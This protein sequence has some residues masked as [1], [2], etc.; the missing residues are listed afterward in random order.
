M[1][2]HTPEFFNFL[3]RKDFDW[4]SIAEEMSDRLM[5]DEF[6][7]DIAEHALDIAFKL[8]PDGSDSDSELMDIRHEFVSEFMEHCRCEYV[9]QCAGNLGMFTREEAKNNADI[10]AAEAVKF[11]KKQLEN[12]ADKFRS[13]SCYEFSQWKLDQ[14]IKEE[15]IPQDSED[16]VWEQM[17]ANNNH[18]QDI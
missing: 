6:N 5:E 7:S 16:E 14:D 3:I 1:I 15:P 9:K 13:M 17:R 12:Q 18:S 10:Q 11:W 2:S 4:D 8:Y